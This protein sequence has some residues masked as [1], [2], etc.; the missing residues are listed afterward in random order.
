MRYAVLLL[1]GAQLLAAE[2]FT[3]VHKRT[4]WHNGR[5]TI[6]I[7]GEGISYQAK[8]PKHSRDW[9][10]L[11]IQYFDRISDTEFAI[12]TYE[13]QRRWLGR[14]RSYR[15]VIEEGRL[16][17]ELFQTISEKLGRPVTNR[18]VRAPAAVRYEVPVKHLHA[19]GGCE[20]T[21]QFTEDAVYYLTGHAKDAREWLLARDVDSVWS[22]NPY[23]LELH[24]YDNNRREFSRTRVYKFDLKEPLNAALYRDLKL[25]LYNLETAHLPFTSDTGPASE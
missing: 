21:L 15:F 3:V 19:F 5:G 4:A 10:W 13:D 22:A 17:D 18:V 8:K 7:T 1:I 23:Q 20:G 16:T 12:L 11:D 24:V 9:S 2:T 6:Q 25:K 14:D